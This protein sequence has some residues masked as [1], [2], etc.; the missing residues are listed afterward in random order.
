M[1]NR[2]TTYVLTDDITDEVFAVVDEH[3][4]AEAVITHQ[5]DLIAQADDEGAIK[6]AALRLQE[7]ALRREYLD[8]WAVACGVRIE[9]TFGDLMDYDTAERIGAATVEQIK[10]SYRAAQTNDTGA[11]R[12]DPT[13]GQVL[14]EGADSAVWP[15]QQT[16]YVA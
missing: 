15:D 2:T 5:A 7:A 1:T 8:D 14:H 6:D 9:Q 11:I 4:I 13:T 3:D 10:A 16:V 12:I